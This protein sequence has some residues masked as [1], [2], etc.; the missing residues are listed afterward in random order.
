MRSP[1]LHS[2]RS[3]ETIPAILFY[4]LVLELC[5]SSISSVVSRKFP[6]IIEVTGPGF[7]NEVRGVQQMRRGASRFLDGAGQSF[8]V[9]GEIGKEVYALTSLVVQKLSTKKH[10]NY[11]PFVLDKIDMLADD[12]TSGWAA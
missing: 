1:G 10:M 11:Q 9:E 4:I 3:K 5:F 2:R 8:F 12:T 6:I 7:A